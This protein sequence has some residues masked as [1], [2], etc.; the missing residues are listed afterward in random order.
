MAL[1]HQDMYKGHY[2]QPQKSVKIVEQTYR[3]KYKKKGHFSS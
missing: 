3:H 1:L 2:A